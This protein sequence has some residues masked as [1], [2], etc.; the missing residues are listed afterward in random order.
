MRIKSG[1]ILF[2]VLIG[3]TL[4]AQIPGKLN[5][6]QGTWEFK[7]GSGFEIWVQ[8]KDSLCGSS[9]RITT[10][11]DTVKVEEMVIYKQE[12]GLIHEFNALHTGNASRSIYDAELNKTRFVN[13]SDEAPHAIRYRFPLFQRRKLQI[14]IYY[15]VKGK[16]SKLNLSRQKQ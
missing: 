8:N 3:T 14:L 6:L 10:G 1:L 11:G 15:G 12:D 5:R 4:A 16:A 13:R 9:F 2:F 7:N